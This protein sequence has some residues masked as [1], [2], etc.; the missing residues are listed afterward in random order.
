MGAQN[1]DP[2]TL[3]PDE[4]VI[5]VHPPLPLVCVSM[6]MERE[7]QQNDSLVKATSMATIRYLCLRRRLCRLELIRFLKLVLQTTT[8]HNHHA[9]W[10]DDPHMIVSCKQ[11]TS[12]HMYTMSCRPLSLLH[13][14][15]M[16]VYLILRMTCTS[17]QRPIRPERCECERLAGRPAHGG[18]LDGLA[19]LCPL[20]PPPR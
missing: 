2:V 8:Q 19:L 15:C 18:L 16:H 6:A 14:F 11:P 17:A 4:T 12:K 9:W 20:L 1:F 3:A 13:V 7:R 5:L 10:P